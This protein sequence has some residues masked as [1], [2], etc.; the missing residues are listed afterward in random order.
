M[1]GF[2][3][4]PRSGVAFGLFTKM[5]NLCSPEQRISTKRRLKATKMD[6]WDPA[7]NFSDHGTTT[8]NFSVQWQKFWKTTGENNEFQLTLPTFFWRQ[9]YHFWA[10]KFETFGT[11]MTNISGFLALYAG[12]NPD[13]CQF[14][15]R[16][17]PTQQ[18]PTSLGVAFLKLFDLSGDNWDHQKPNWDF[19]G[20]TSQKQLLRSV[21]N[22][23]KLSLFELF[24][25]DI[26]FR[27]ERFETKILKYELNFRGNKFLS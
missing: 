10:S 3:P 12:W 5:K 26:S 25:T 11:K 20:A 8:L 27:F 2:L 9:V 23:G 24:S 22:L 21:H 14:K 6:P 4:M 13:T 16:T 17:D 1:S 7:D 19:Y 15:L 18:E